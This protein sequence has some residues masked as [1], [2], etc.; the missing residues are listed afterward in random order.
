[1]SC[2]LYTIEIYKRKNFKGD[3]KMKNKKLPIIIA[4]V[5]LSIIGIAVIKLNNKETK[6]ESTETEQAEQTEPTDQQSQQDFYFEEDTKK[7]TY[8]S[9]VKLETNS[10]TNGTDKQNNEHI[11]EI[12]LVNED[13][14]VTY[15]IIDNNS[16]KYNNTTY[17]DLY[18]CINNINSKYSANTIINFIIKTHKSTSDLVYVDVITDDVNT[19]EG[20]SIDLTL[21]EE[22]QG[23]NQYESIKSKYNNEP[24]TWKLTLTDSETMYPTYIYGCN[25]YMLMT[26]T[27]GN[28]QIDMSAYDSGLNIYQSDQSSDQS[29]TTEEQTNQSEDQSTEQPE[30]LT[31]Q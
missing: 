19:S 6:P 16:V 9:P 18:T 5:T 2:F 29:E 30:P 20:D 31:E 22:L 8:E 27:N 4:I 24:V 7:D 15:S 12:E 23:Y 28:I 11:G 3:R 26:G 14:S 13:T 21:D 17:Q 10:I 1:M 25:T